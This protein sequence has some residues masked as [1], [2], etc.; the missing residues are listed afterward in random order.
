MRILAVGEDAAIELAELRR[1]LAACGAAP[2]VQGAFVRLDGDPDPGAGPRDALLDLRSE[3][4][5]EGRRWNE[6]Y[7][8]A[9]VWV[10]RKLGKHA[11][12]GFDLAKLS[13]YRNDV[14]RQDALA[15]ALRGGRDPG[16]TVT[17]SGEPPADLPAEAQGWLYHNRGLG[18]IEEHAGL[19]PFF[20]VRPS[21]A[22]RHRRGRPSPLPE[23]WHDAV[24]LGSMGDRNVVDVFARIVATEYPERIRALVPVWPD[25]AAPQ[26]SEKA[27]IMWAA[28]KGERALDRAWPGPRLD[29]RLS[30][31]GLR[32]V[33]YLEALVW[34]GEPPFP[35]RMGLARVAVEARYMGQPKTPVALEAGT[36]IGVERPRIAVTVGAWSDGL[37]PGEDGPEWRLVLGAPLQRRFDR[38]NWRVEVEG[39][40]LPLVK[41]HASEF[42]NLL[43][44][45]GLEG[46]PVLA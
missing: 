1:R 2:T 30:A 36:E 31:S 34:C 8:S 17:F 12:R 22:W 35:R 7:A 19:E 3:G 11:F 15:L 16:E 33:D 44:V 27:G 39:A 21:E 41:A 10:R 29:I 9:K 46:P 26:A 40:E 18:A 6:D 28:R 38:G 25:G 24:V 32:P 13:G 37:G 23:D 42:D 45:V 20:G 4:G 43:A 5:Q 14:A